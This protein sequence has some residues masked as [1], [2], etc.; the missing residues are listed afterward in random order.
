MVSLVCGR[1]SCELK[2]MVVSRAGGLGRCW[3]EGTDTRL[4]V[5]ESSMVT[6]VGS[7]NMVGLTRVVCLNG[8]EGCASSPYCGT[9]FTGYTHT[10]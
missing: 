4:Q 5:N 9:E 8:I 1:E 7:T 6:T 2:R 10:E 3:S